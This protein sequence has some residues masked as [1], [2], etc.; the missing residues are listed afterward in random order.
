MRA[1]HEQARYGRTQRSVTSPDTVAPMMT[2]MSAPST[3]SASS[4]I[5]FGVG[6][7]VLAPAALAVETCVFKHTMRQPGRSE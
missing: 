5:R 1:G 3:P 7:R 2:R 4:A 6:G